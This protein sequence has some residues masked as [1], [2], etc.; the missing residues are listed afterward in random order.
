L[1]KE[2][3]TNG[4]WASGGWKL[5]P[6]WLGPQIPMLESSVYQ[7]G[8]IVNT[9]SGLDFKTINTI[10]HVYTQQDE[11]KPLTEKLFADK[12]LVASSES[13]EK[14]LG[15]FS[16]L[17]DVLAVENLLIA[18]YEKSLKQVKTKAATL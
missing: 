8:I 17:H 3:L 1:N 14:V 4:F 10:A 5:T 9:L 16:W 2:V 11:Y 15:T 12:V 18:E 6:G 7:T 13:T